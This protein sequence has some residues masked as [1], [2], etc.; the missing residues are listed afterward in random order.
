MVETCML[1]RQSQYAGE[2]T[3]EDVLYKLESLDLSDY[4]E[5]IEFRTL[6]EKL[7]KAYK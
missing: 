3:L 6:A 7:F 4:P 5:R 2:L 1:L